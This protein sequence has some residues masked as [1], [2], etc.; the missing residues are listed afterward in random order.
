MVR[1]I[2]RSVVALLTGVM[3]LALV[4]VSSLV[5]WHEARFL[6]EEHRASAELLAGVLALTLDPAAPPAHLPAEMAADVRSVELKDSAGRVVWRWGPAAEAV[7]EASALVVRERTP[8]GGEVVLTASP[9]RL[10]RHLRSTT[11]RALAGLVVA[12]AVSLAVGLLLAG[13][14]S[15]PLRELARQARDPRPAALASPR[16]IASGC[17]E[18][19]EL[20]AA[21]ADMRQRL[22]VEEERTVRALATLAGGVAHDFNNL[23]AGVEV[24][25][26]WMER[27]ESAQPQAVAAIRSL[28]AEGA[29]VVQELLLAA[30]RETTPVEDLDL[31][32]LVRDQEGVLRH[33][34]PA[35]VELEVRSASPQVL[36][37]ANPVAIRRL[38]LN[39]VLNGGE[40]VAPGRGR[41]LVRVA[42]DGGRALLEV[43]DD[44]VGV[45][46]EVR[47]RMFDPFYSERRQGRGAGL[48]LAVVYAVVQEHSGTISVDS[49]PGVGTTVRVSLPLLRRGPPRA[50]SPVAGSRVLLVSPSSRTAGEVLETL[51]DSGLQVR[52]DLDLEAGR[53]TL[54]GWGADAVVVDQGWPLEVAAAAISPVRVPTVLVAR[55]AGRVEAAGDGAVLLEPPLDAGR[56]LEVLERLL[57]GGD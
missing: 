12:F 38:L 34:L 35:A 27:D 51:A 47:G 33:L 54:T 25:L 2:G 36:V 50:H 57:H 7:P 45:R 6:E 4:W 39:L 20:S 26:R 22:A 31:V 42:A 1:S 32:D 5:L 53:Q 3:A 17:A 14:V 18:V 43:A 28:A 46:P 23:L 48:G 10:R 29:E 49:E 56:L 16:P 44:G 11:G 24:H 40:A 21:L 8:T 15:G 37:A 13:R 55:A 41:V 19:V 52:H 30:R 9:G